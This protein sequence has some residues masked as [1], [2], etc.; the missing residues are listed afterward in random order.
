[1]TLNISIK[2]T[3]EPIDET[4]LIRS[5]QVPAT[6]GAAVYFMGCVRGMEANETIHAL[7]YEAYEAMARHQFEKLFEEAGKRWPI[8]SIRVVHRV[9]SVSVGE[10]AV[11]IEVI[12]PHRTEAFQ[13]CQWAVDEMKRVVPI[14]KKPVA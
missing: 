4:A 8:Q 6:A 3:R 1:M 2:L 10:P 13:A 11:W 14:W 12:A 9:G 7:E 5:R